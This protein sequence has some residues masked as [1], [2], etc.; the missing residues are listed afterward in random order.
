MFI[1]L[2]INHLKVANL[3]ICVC[4]YKIDINIETIFP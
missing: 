4:N 2:H 3:I 1:L